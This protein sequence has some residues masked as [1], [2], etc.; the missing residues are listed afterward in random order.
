MNFSPRKRDGNK[1]IQ[2]S[3]NAN[4]ATH[5]PFLKKKKKKPEP[6]KKK[7]QTGGINRAQK[8]INIQVFAQTDSGSDSSIKLPSKIRTDR[9]FQYLLLDS[10]EQERLETPAAGK[11]ARTDFPREIPG[12]EF[13]PRAQRTLL[14]VRIKNERMRKS[15][16]FK[17]ACLRAI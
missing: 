1:K 14:Y 4:T 8:P 7:P 2:F 10:L 5:Q 3:S 16:D 6:K 12:S 13:F 15:R 9:V 17:V 11:F